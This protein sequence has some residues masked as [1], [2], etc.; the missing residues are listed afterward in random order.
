MNRLLTAVP[1]LG[2]LIFPGAATAQFTVALARSTPGDVRPVF[3]F[4]GTRWSLAQEQEEYGQRT[5]PVDG[6]QAPKVWWWQGKHRVEVGRVQRIARL[7]WGQPLLEA[8][9]PI[10]SPADSHRM[11]V[12]LDRPG[13]D[14][15]VLASTFD[16][17]SRAPMAAAILGAL[18]T[19]FDD[20]IESRRGERGY[21]GRF[22]EPWFPTADGRAPTVF[23]QLSL[24]ESI[25]NGWAHV[26]L[27]RHFH[28]PAGSPGPFCWDIAALRGWVRLD[29]FEVVADHLTFEIDDCDGKGGTWWIPEAAVRV[30]GRE[31]LIGIESMYEMVVPV[32]LEVT[33]DGVVEVLR[34]FSWWGDE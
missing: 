21:A 8:P 30:G 17:W 19:R 23:D 13:M 26:R 33:P 2:A 31:F 32:V 24:L 11:R 15:R 9:W 4:D 12:V 3:H 5:T 14:I 34:S 7:F 29:G 18:E 22:E 25:P 1:L 6:W 10:S 28:R 27:V 16:S 20:E